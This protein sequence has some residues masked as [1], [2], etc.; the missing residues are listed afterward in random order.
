MLARPCLPAFLALA[1]ALLLSGCGGEEGGPTDPLVDRLPDELTSAVALDL[2]AI[3]AKLELPEDAD[4]V[5]GIVAPEGEEEQAEE[6]EGDGDDPTDAER[7]LAALTSSALTYIG[8]PAG[9]D[10]LAEAIDHGQVSAIA[11]GGS[12]ET[13]PVG[14]LRTEQDPDAIAAALSEEGWEPEG[15][16]IVDATP[17]PSQAFT[18]MAAEEGLLALASS[19]QSARALLTGFEGSEEETE[20]AEA[21]PDA[22]ELIGRMD[23]M[24]RLA[25]LLEISD[26]LRSIAVTDGVTG[27]GELLFEPVGEPSLDRVEAREG[28]DPLPAPLTSFS[29]G[30]PEIEDDIYV[31][32]P[33]TYELPEERTLAV[34]P[35]EA[36]RQGIQE[37]ALYEC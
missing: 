20:T 1:V 33:L 16:A 29:F 10:V 3:R 7:R 32:V 35:L 11:A 22:G 15:E 24:A 27:D 37:E 9:E 28:G 5:A 14:V 12:T 34:G 25:A 23:G 36:V 18:A 21:A 17:Q 30:D 31:R 19:A 26:C 6:G 2:T 8:D 4:P 13:G